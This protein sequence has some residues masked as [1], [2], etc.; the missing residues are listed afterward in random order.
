MPT[1]DI[2]WTAGAAWGSLITLLGLLIRQII[3]WRKQRANEF[4]I[5]I[6]SYKAELDRQRERISTLER[7]LDE[8][9]DHY[10]RQFRYQNESHEAEISLHRHATRNAK[11]IL[12]GLLDL[13]EAAPE[14]AS[15]HA[16]KMRDRMIA[17]DKQEAEEAATIRSAK[18]IASVSVGDTTP[19]Q[20]ED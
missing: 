2:D 13:V 20:D 9:R 4:E 3:P 8:Q 1:T 17:L 19:H 5:A 18:I 15:A 16:S 11:Q 7:K 6:A 10:E 14:A 12:Y